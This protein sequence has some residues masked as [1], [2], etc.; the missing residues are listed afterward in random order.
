MKKHLQPALLEGLHGAREEEE[1]AL[2]ALLSE[3]VVL[4]LKCTDAL[5]IFPIAG[6]FHRAF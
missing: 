5:V 3:A 1:N 2:I 4:P 6:S